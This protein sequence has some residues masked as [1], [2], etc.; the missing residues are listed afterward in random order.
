MVDPGTSLKTAVLDEVLAA[1]RGHRFLYTSES[2][3]QEGIHHLLEQGGLNAVREVRLS[4]RDRIDLLV[5]RI[6][7]E[8]KVAGSQTHPWDQLKRYAGHDQI[9]VLIL[10]TNRVYRLPDEVGGKPLYVVS[11][12]GIGL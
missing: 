9:E 5:D 10:V 2:E 8:V 11:L 12:A 1:L 4:D 3:L 7:I 6:G